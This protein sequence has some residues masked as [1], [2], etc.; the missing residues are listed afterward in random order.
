[1][2]GVELLRQLFFTVYTKC[3]EVCLYACLLYI[4]AQCGALR[5]HAYRDIAS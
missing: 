3:S 5:I 4:K 2:P 1:M